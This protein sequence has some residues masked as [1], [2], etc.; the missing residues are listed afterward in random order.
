MQNKNYATTEWV[1]CKETAQ[2]LTHTEPEITI[3]HLT[4]S[5]HFWQLSE[6]KSICSDKVSRQNDNKDNIISVNIR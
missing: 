2:K 5:N 6:Q 4:I 3:R 1:I